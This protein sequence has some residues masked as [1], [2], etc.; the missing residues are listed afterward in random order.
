MDMCTL[1]DI[2]SNKVKFTSEA[3]LL[4][5]DGIRGIDVKLKPTKTKIVIVYVGFIIYFFNRRFKDVVR[6][7]VKKDLGAKTKYKFSI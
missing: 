4:V 5:L 6:A 7:K 3:E 2:V 1:K